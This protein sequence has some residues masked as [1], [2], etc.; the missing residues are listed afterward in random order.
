[1]TNNDTYC[2]GPSLEERRR[3]TA[4]SPFLLG[5]VIHASRGWVRIVL[6]AGEGAELLC[7]LTG[8]MG[9]QGIQPVAGDWVLAEDLGSDQGVI[10]EVLERR[11]LLRRRAAGETSQ[12][13]LLGANLDWICIVTA[14]DRDWNPR[15]LE[16]FGTLAWDS[17]AEN[18]P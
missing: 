1:M 5:R 10:R 14:P 15:R 7:R 3:E 17:G 8:K 18:G 13:Q 16:R 6:P 9:R 11:S 2:W 12:D 4:D